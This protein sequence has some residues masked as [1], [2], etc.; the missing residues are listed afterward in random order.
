MTCKRVF[1]LCPDNEPLWVR[2]YAH[3]IGEI[4]VAM[5][6]ATTP[7]RPNQAA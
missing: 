5:I 7:Y 1:A 6:V 3:Q 4:W 2:L